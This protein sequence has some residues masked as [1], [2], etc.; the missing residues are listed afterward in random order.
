[1]F[2]KQFEARVTRALASAVTPKLSK[3]TPTGIIQLPCSSG[4]QSTQQVAKEPSSF[5]P[6]TKTSMEK[7]L[8]RA[9][10]NA[11]HT[12]CCHSFAHGRT[13][14]ARKNYPANPIFIGKTTP[15]A[16][17]LPV[18]LNSQQHM[19]S[20]HNQ[21]HSPWYSPAVTLIHMLFI[22]GLCIPTKQ[23][24]TEHQHQHFK[25]RLLRTL[26]HHFVEVIPQG[27]RSQDKTIYRTSHIPS[28]ENQDLPST[29]ST[30]ASK[31]KGK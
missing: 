11:S 6:L 30:T 19:P 25:N 12:V 18:P 2:I 16:T 7:P 8:C 26:E 29:E 17:S 13:A 23:S 22:I 15:F 27:P 4:L 14:T 28:Y 3:C 9:I 1:M 20:L 10:V 21:T 5:L 31:S 24:F